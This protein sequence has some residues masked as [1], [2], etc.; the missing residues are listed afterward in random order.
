MVYVDK[1]FQTER[2][3]KWRYPSACHL[4]ADTLEE[5]HE[6]ALRLGLRRTYFQDHPRHPHYDITEGRRK[7]AVRL[8]AVEK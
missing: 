3:S 6:F 5:L 7:L 8:G 4:T 1:L 2:S